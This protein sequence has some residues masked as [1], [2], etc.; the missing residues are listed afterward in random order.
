[1]ASENLIR[2]QTTLIFQV[3]ASNLDYKKI[4]FLT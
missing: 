3:M 2:K 4:I 1:M